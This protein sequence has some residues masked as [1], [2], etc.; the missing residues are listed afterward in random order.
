MR[1]TRRQ[2][3]EAYPMPLAVF[4]IA[5]PS[6]SAL[7]A[8]GLW[9]FFCWKITSKHGPTHLAKLPGIATSFR[10]QHWF[11]RLPSL[12]GIRRDGQSPTN[13]SDRQ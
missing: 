6:A 1:R 9:L 12:P 8:W 11:A 10:A 2:T 13:T 4:L 3:L 7:I 5:I